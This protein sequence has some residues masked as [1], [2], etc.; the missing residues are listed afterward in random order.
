MS[1]KLTVGVHPDISIEDYHADKSWFSST[2]LKHA[3]RSMK[4]FKYFL[5]GKLDSG[6]KQCFD[7]GNAFELA[8]LS[9]EEYK[10]KVVDESVIM[11]ELFDSEK[12]RATKRYKEWVAGQD[13]K[14]IISIED[15]ITIEEMLVSCSSDKTISR[16]IE[17]IEYNYSLCWVSD[18]GLQL[19]ARPDIC[20]A[21]KNVVVNL[22]TTTDA[23]PSSFSKDMVNFDY[24]FQAT[25]EIEG[26]LRSGF[27]DSV[28]NYYWLVVEKNRPHNAVL[29]EFM[30]E[31]RQAC[32]FAYD[33]VMSRVARAVHHNHFGGYEE[34]AENQFGILNAIIPSYYYSPKF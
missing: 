10:S 5:D 3:K 34:L 2:G 22:K 29:Y 28:D 23:S 31:D 11:D 4:E 13:G 15:K 17:N 7:F 24:P 21:K 26:C 14:Y 9:P 32:K 33:E 6:R 20:K 27:M 18:D 30:P 1:S 8:L 25:H 12:P 16:L 19:K